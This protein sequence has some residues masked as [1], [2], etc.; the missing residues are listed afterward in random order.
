MNFYWFMDYET[1]F[2]FFKNM[3]RLINRNSLKAL[4]YF[5][6]SPLNIK[7]RKKASFINIKNNF[8]RKHFSSTR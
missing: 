5:N 1:F 4:W 3:R 7:T 8:T 2:R 6:E